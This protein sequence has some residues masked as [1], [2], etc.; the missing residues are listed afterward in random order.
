VTIDVGGVSECI[1]DKE[2]GYLFKEDE[3]AIIKINHLFQNAHHRSQISMRA[4][5]FAQNNFSP[6]T[7]ANKYLEVYNEVNERITKDLI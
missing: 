2:T 4:R 1:I 6:K 5:N 3:E 7:I